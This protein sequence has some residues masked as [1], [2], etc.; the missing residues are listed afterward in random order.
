MTDLTWPLIVVLTEQASQAER[1]R[2]I[3]TAAQYRVLTVS[4][5]QTA[6]ARIAGGGVDLVVLC[7]SPHPRRTPVSESIASLA[8]CAAGLPVIVF[9]D[10]ESIPG[11]PPAVPE[12]DLV[13]TARRLIAGHSEPEGSARIISLQGVKGGVGAST[14]ALNLAA[15]LTRQGKTILAEMRAGLGSLSSHLRPRRKIRT[16]ADLTAIQADAI[17]AADLADCLWPCPQIP[18][19]SILFGP[20][21]RVRDCDWTAHVSRILRIAAASADYLVVDLPHCV[22][23]V[24]RAVLR[25]TDNFI[26]LLERDALCLEAG[27]R[28]LGALDS[29]S[30]LPHSTAAVVVSRV[31]LAAPVELAEVERELNLPVIGSLPP[32]PDLCLLAYQSQ[33]AVVALDPEALLASSYARLAEK[34]TA[35]LPAAHPRRT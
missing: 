12:Q 35:A 19:M 5:C 26:L 11:M 25:A 2:G 29:E 20:Q 7:V 10:G 6:A 4:D 1:L 23:A 14:T 27:K 15:L 18:G 28:M 8:K 33:T 17:T 3:L 21:S 30:L 32:A 13:S 31:P 16:L 9:G 24:N 34:L 22:S